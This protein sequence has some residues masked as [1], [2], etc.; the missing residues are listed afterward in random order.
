MTRSNA[1]TGE[2]ARIRKRIEALDAE[3]T[4]LERRLAELAPPQLPMPA[5]ATGGAKLTNRSPVRDKIA[6]LSEPLSRPGGRVS[7]ALGKCWQGNGRVCA[8]LRQ[9]VEARGVPQT[10]RAVRGLSEPGLRAVHRRRRR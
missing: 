1:G 10:S 9:R 6:A 3:R 8:G 5:I 2:A 7:P 4:A